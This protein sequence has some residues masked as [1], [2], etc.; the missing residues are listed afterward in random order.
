MALLQL[1]VSMMIGAVIGFFSIYVP[2]EF[3]VSSAE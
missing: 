1:P 3:N 2:N